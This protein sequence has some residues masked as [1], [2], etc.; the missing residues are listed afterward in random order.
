VK[1]RLD[2]TMKM[3]ARV[4]LHSIG[5]IHNEDQQLELLLLRARIAAMLEQERARSEPTKEGA[6]N[7]EEQKPLPF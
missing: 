5:E 4:L 7:G 1:H 6:H 2:Y 3:C